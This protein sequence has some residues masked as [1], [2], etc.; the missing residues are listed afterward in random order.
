MTAT[1]G[2]AG[3]VSHRWSKRLIMVLEG[4][5]DRER[6]H[7]GRT[8]AASGDVEDLDVRPG[9]VYASVRGTRRRPYSVT[10]RISV[11]TPDQWS[12]VE[13]MMAARTDLYTP[14]LEGRMPEH[15]EDVFHD[16]GLSLY[17]SRR[18]FDADCTCPDLVRPCKHIAATCYVLADRLDQDPFDLML[19]RG[20]RKI[21]L[22]RRLESLRDEQS[23]E[24]SETA[25]EPED[26]PLAE[27]LGGFWSGTQ[28][29]PALPAAPE[30]ARPGA[31]LDRLGPLG[32]GVSG[33]GGR[34]E[35]DLTDLLRPAYDAL[36]RG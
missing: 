21:D 1:Q 4:F 23:W 26:V 11:L 20:R 19:W 28:P 9:E 5:S 7:R 31:I 24:Q 33:E 10:I 12:R 3:P 14:L 34:G 27:A 22:Q 16:T 15:V 36:A 2:G 30:E 6:L 35:P 17:P 13:R 32:V 25:P 18:E 29:L 8:Y